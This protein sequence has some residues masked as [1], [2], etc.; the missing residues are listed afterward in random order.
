MMICKHGVINQWKDIKRASK[1]KWTDR[2]FHVQDNADVAQKDVI[3][4]CDNNQFPVL[5]FCGSH[6]KP[7]RTRGFG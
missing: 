6:L 1:I 7:H 2:E 5:P 4:N 3:V